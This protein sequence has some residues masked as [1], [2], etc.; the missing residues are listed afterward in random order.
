MQ[1]SGGCAG[2][3][4]PAT[5]ACACLDLI[6][7]PQA[8]SGRA[9]VYSERSATVGSTF[10]ARSAGM[11]EAR[12]D[13]ASRISGAVTSTTGSTAFTPYRMPWS[14]C[15]APSGQQQADPDA[16]GRDAAALSQHLPQHG[17]V[18]ARQWRFGCR[19]RA[20]GATRR[21]T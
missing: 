1:L 6:R 9:L 7:Q 17:R 15:P 11:Y 13:A 21:T 10:V 18:D 2:T 4:R 12:S 5:F 8:A 16:D 3:S 19:T 20:S 14:S